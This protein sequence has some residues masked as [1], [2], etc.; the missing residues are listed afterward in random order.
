MVSEFQYH[1]YPT[2]PLPEIFIQLEWSRD[3]N[4]LA[5]SLLSLLCRGLFLQLGSWGEGSPK[6]GVGLGYLLTIFHYFH[7]FGI[8]DGT[9]ENNK[10]CVRAVE[11]LGNLH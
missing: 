6:R 10:V 11:G 5:L 2:L 9:L 8:L 1:H 3:P 4:R 7:I